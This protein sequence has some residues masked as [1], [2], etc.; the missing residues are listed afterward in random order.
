MAILNFW[1]ENNFYSILFMLKCTLSGER[2]QEQSQ[3]PILV[4]RLLQLAHT[5]NAPF[6]ASAT[7]QQ[8]TTMGNSKAVLLPNCSELSPSAR[9]LAEAL[10][11]QKEKAK[12]IS[13]FPKPYSLMSISSGLCMPA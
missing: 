12:G 6:E 10:V 2:E 11:D 5:G 4:H 3:H 1:I 13:N 9:G 8:G 7:E